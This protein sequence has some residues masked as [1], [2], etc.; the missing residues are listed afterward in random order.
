MNMDMEY[1][2]TSPFPVH[3]GTV[4]E[5]IGGP[6]QELD[7]LRGGEVTVSPGLVQTQPLFQ[8]HLRLRRLRH[9]LGPFLKLFSVRPLKMVVPEE[10][11]GEER[12]G[13]GEE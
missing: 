12:E 10:E 3:S 9:T 4:P 7:T 6:R 5:E 8:G 2:N 11:G 13:E 1:Q